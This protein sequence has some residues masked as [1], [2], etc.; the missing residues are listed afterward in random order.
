MKRGNRVLLAAIVTLAFAHV[1]TAGP[2][3]ILLEELSVPAAGGTVTTTTTLLAGNLYRIEASGTFSAGAEITADA[4]YSSGPDSYAWQDL[5]E[6][7]EQYGEGL[8]ELKVNGSFVEW[9]PYNPDHVYTLDMVGT[10]D[11]VVFTFEIYDTY[12]LNNVGGLTAKIYTVPVPGAFLL[13][14]LGV[15]MAGYLCR[16]RTL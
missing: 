14:S 6:K 4:E 15:S 10:G 11:P 9:G 2:S 16:R 3:W 12:P 8:L 1:A 7:Y 5:V 13:A